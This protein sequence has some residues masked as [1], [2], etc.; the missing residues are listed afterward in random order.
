MLGV[1]SILAPRLWM[2][3]TFTSE[4]LPTELG[5]CLAS[6]VSFTLG[7]C[8]MPGS[9]VFSLIVYLLCV[10]EACASHT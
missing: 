3:V 1:S 7:K 9:H 6:H 5:N 10:P 8:V 2:A 4:C